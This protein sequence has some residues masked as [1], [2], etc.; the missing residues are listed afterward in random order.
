MVVLGE[1]VTKG[2]SSQQPAADGADNASRSHIYVPDYTVEAVT[3]LVVVRV[4]VEQYAGALHAA[5]LDRHLRSVDSR[6]DGRGFPAGQD[7]D[8]SDVVG[9]F[10]TSSDAPSPLVEY[11]SH[12]QL[13]DGGT[14]GSTAVKDCT[15]VNNQTKSCDV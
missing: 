4:T 7:G 1:M 5:S 2:L 3:D 6:G 14:S 11:T 12:E 13:L 8:I 10:P 15:S 9:E